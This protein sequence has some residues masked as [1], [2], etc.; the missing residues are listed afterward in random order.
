MKKLLLFF[1]LI[2]FSTALLS[3]KFKNSSNAFFYENKGQIID[4]NGN[5]NPAVKY[6]FN[7]A[8]I[9]VQLKNEG[10]SYD[11]YEVENTLK[12]RI[13]IKEIDLS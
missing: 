2:S 6:L 5:K 10:F 11:V 4:Q 3:Q 13:D 9:N 7:A 8:G 12:K 1:F